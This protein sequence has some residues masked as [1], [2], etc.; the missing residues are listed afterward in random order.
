MYF[1]IKDIVRKIYFNYNIAGYNIKKKIV[2]YW[3]KNE[4]Y[5]RTL[6]QRRI[7]G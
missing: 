5:C 3:R 2:L 6:R 7:P 4:G 1:V